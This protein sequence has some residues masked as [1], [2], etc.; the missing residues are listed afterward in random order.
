LDWAALDGEHHHEPATTRQWRDYLGNLT[1][2]D[3]IYDR[4]STAADRKLKPDSRYQVVPTST[5]PRRDPH[6]AISSCGV[7]RRLMGT[8]PRSR[9]TSSPPFR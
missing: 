5:G 1:V 9:P 6:T 8:P 2:A 3:P 7:S 4:L